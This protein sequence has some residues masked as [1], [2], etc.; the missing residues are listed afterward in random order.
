MY[1]LVM[2]HSKSVKG[3]I[4]QLIRKHGSVEA[5]AKEFKQSPRYIEMLQDGKKKAAGIEEGAS[6]FLLLPVS[7]SNV[8]SWAV[9]DAT[10]SFHWR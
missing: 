10:V 8:G 6:R 5:V 2:K 4:K 9:S 3:L 1:S 7:P